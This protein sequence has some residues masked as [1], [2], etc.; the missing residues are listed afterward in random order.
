MC[1][2]K[3]KVRVWKTANPQ[4]SSSSSISSNIINHVI[5]VIIIIII[6]AEPIRDQGF[7]KLL[8]NSTQYV[9]I[10]K[11]LPNLPKIF[12]AILKLISS[13]INIYCNMLSKRTGVIVMVI[14]RMFTY[15]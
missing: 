11:S 14:Q 12:I 15:A 8:Y 5:K 6:V 2:H 3:L 7:N 10:G 1:Q 9:W 13:C 4:N